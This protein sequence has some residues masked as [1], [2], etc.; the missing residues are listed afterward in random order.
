MIELTLWQLAERSI[1]RIQRMNAL[2]P[3]CNFSEI[4]PVTLSKLR[5]RSEIETLHNEQQTDEML[6]GFVLM[7]SEPPL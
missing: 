5:A 4:I 6:A 2:L 3:A 1:P 7:K